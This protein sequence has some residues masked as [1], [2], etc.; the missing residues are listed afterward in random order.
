M[1]TEIYLNLK[2]SWYEVWE[3]V[4]LWLVKSPH[5]QFGTANLLPSKIEN[6]THEWQCESAVVHA[7]G[8]SQTQ[9]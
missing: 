6:G 9:P 8:R 2:T 5:S 7:P 4:R 3:A 1:K